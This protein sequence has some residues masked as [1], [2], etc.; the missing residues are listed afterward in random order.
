[1][2]EAEMGHLRTWPQESSSWSS[3]VGH[4]SSVLTE[5]KQ[6]IFLAHLHPPRVATPVPVLGK[7]VMSWPYLSTISFNPCN[8][9]S[10]RLVQPRGQELR[11]LQ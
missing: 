2:R 10:T 1:M 7:V 3:S 5:D 4:P 9:P 11:G 6:L 8:S